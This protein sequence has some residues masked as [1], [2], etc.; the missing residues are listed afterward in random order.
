MSLDERHLISNGR[1]SVPTDPIWRLTVGQYHEMIDQG[2]LTD[3]DPVELLEGWLVR[4]MS[5]NPPHSTATRR[6]RLALG[7]L[8]LAGF[9]VD[10][11]EP[12][13]TEDSEPEPDIC[14]IRGN[15]E[16]Y[17]TKHPGP[18]DVP[19]LVE[20]SDTTLETDRVSKKRAYARAGFA[21]YWIINLVDRVVEVYGNPTGPSQT[22]SYNSQHVYRPGDRVPVVVDDRTLGSIAVS[23]LLPN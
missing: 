14:I 3:D 5:K 2:I 16:D 15:I 21:V 4:K 9:Y 7:R 18:M 20:V 6:T 22:P 12:V 23:D 11:Q 19:L 1:A 17:T 10:S 13:T 8:V